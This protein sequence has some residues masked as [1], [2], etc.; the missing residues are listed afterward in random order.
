MWFGVQGFGFR[1]LNPRPPKTQIFG[2]GQGWNETTGEPL[3][4]AALDDAPEREGFRGFG[5]GF[6]VVGLWGLGF[7][8]SRLGLW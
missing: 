7:R 1:V 5:F 8:V 3:L 4:P 2:P 6:G